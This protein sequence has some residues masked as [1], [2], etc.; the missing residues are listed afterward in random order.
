MYL[1]VLFSQLPFLLL[2]GFHSFVKYSTQ[3]IVAIHILY[4]DIQK[5]LR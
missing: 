4:N 2:F 1:T 5:F 3:Q